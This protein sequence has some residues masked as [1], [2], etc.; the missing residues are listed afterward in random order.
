MRAADVDEV[1]VLLGEIVTDTKARGDALGFFAA[2]YR[3]VTLEVKHG[4]GDNFFDD[5]PRMNRFVALFANRYLDAY[6]A[7]TGGREPTRAWWVAFEGVR[8]GRLL[9]L[10]NLLLGINAHINL[11]LG[12][13]TGETFEGE[14][15]DD[16]HADFDRVNGI[17][18]SLIPRVEDAIQRFSPLMGVLEMVG[19]ADA[20]EAL[21]F[22]VDRARDDAWLN[23]TLLSRQPSFLGP[24]TTSALDKK[25]A[26]L[27]RLVSQPI[28]PVAAAVTLIRSSES[29]DVPAIITALDGIVER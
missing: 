16:F 20:L 4:I 3:Q 26:F 21:D 24:I 14:A 10:Q 13:V 22:S 2:L 1:L 7:Y 25:A 5:G 28:G 27:G 9:I 18:G 29:A 23:A 17:L 8:S 12:V 11:D 19:G 15:L 6:G